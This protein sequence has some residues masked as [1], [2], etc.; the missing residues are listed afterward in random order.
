MVDEDDKAKQTVTPS[1]LRITNSIFLN[2]GPG[3][4]FDIQQLTPVDVEAS[5][6][7]AQGNLGSVVKVKQ[8]EPSPI[9][10]LVAAVGLHLNELDSITQ[11]R[12]ID[13]VSAYRNGDPA[14]KQGVLETLKTIGLEVAGTAAGTAIADWIAD[15]IKN[16]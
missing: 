1:K 15:W 3:G 2:N 4:F 13:A 5:N 16:P 7:L 14:Q 6:V 11:R 8:L 10:A 9:N 12:F